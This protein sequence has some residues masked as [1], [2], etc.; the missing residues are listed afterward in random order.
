MENTIASQQAQGPR[1]SI[2]LGDGH[3]TQRAYRAFRARRPLE[4]KGEFSW[5][6]EGWEA[7]AIDSDPVPQVATGHGS[8]ATIN[9]KV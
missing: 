8:I 9:L 5:I 6:R 4:F 1:S 3:S 7:H 2:G